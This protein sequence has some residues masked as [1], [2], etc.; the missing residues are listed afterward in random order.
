[1]T[2]AI[3]NARGLSRAFRQAAETALPSVVMLITKSKPESLRGDG[4]LRRLL[5]NPRLRGL[6]PDQLPGESPDG[7]ADSPTIKTGVGSGVII[8]ASGISLTNSLVVQVADEIVAR[9]ESGQEL[10]VIE[11]KSDPASELAIVRITPEPSQPLQAARLGESEPLQIGD[12]VIA[13]GN[14]FELEATVSA[15]I[16]SG[17]GRGIDKVRRGRLLQTDAAINPGNSGGPLVDLEGQVVGINTAI[18]SMNGGYQGIGFAIPIDRAKWVA[19]ELLTQGRVRRA[20]LGIGI[21]ELTAE[22]AVKLKL[23][24]RAGVFVRDVLPGSPADAAGIKINDVIVEFAG[25]RT[26]GP[27]DLQDIVEQ[28][29]IG[30]QQ[31]VK[32]M[33]DGTP[34][35]VSVTLQELKED[36]LR[37][38]P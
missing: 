37:R 29:P 24:A 35:S 27:R 26:P 28:K 7:S 30:S 3:S 32:V 1:M 23:P 19:Q 25:Q 12:W 8:D 34:V 6:L 33:R 14:P 11:V 20:S 5:E 15:G 17:K 38:R 31:T 10:K 2:V 22:A 21:E 16:I 36:V 4:D 9:L 18:A 13:I